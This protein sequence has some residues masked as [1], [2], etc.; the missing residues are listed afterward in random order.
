M[1]RDSGFSSV[2]LR[3]VGDTGAFR[4][5]GLLRI[6]RTVEAEIKMFRSASWFAIRIRPQ[7]TLDFVISHTRDAVSVGVLFAG[8][9]PIFD[10]M[11]PPVESRSGDTKVLSNSAPWYLECFHMPEDE[12]PFAKGVS[13]VLL[14]LLDPFLKDRYLHFQLVNLISKKD[15]FFVLGVGVHGSKP[16]QA[17]LPN[18]S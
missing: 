16:F 17:L 7:L 13:R 8:L 18:S 15:D 12:K 5:V 10:L 3:V 6:L 2:F 1:E 4:G 11:Q 9:L 14:F